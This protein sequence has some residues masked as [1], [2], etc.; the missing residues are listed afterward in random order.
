MVDDLRWTCVRTVA[1]LLN[2]DVESGHLHKTPH[3]E[4]RTP[5]ANVFKGTGDLGFKALLK[6][7]VSNLQVPSL[8]F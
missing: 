8:G 7:S 3:A 5:Q 6:P 1:L 4:G 2:L